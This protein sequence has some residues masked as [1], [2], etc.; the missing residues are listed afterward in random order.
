MHRIAKIVD[1][2]GELHSAL[3]SNDVVTTMGSLFR[4]CN[5]VRHAKNSDIQQK[6]KKICVSP[7]V[8]VEMGG[9]TL[10]K[11]IHVGSSNMDHLENLIKT[12]YARG[13]KIETDVT[14]SDIEW[15][16]F[17]THMNSTLRCTYPCLVR[18][19]FEAL[20]CIQ[21]QCMSSDKIDS[22]MRCL[23]EIYTGVRGSNGGRAQDGNVSGGALKRYIDLT[24]E[25]FS[26]DGTRYVAFKEVYNE[27]LSKSQLSVIL[28]NYNKRMKSTVTSGKQHN[29]PGIPMT[30]AN[31]NDTTKIEIKMLNFLIFDCMKIMDDMCQNLCL[32]K[33]DVVVSYGISEA[34]RVQ[35]IIQS[36]KSSKYDDLKEQMRNVYNHTRK[37]KLSNYSDMNKSDIIDFLQK[38]WLCYWENV[39]NLNLESRDMKDKFSVWTHYIETFLNQLLD[40]NTEAIFGTFYLYINGNAVQICFRNLRV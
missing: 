27:E 31:G 2:A 19:F 9:D 37:E 34:T 6:L 30:I 28:S 16:K 7:K 35:K 26:P 33:S 24:T 20:E 8:T 23:A 17:E 32:T 13:K 10:Q 36:S 15:G 11:N 4:I 1:E 12:A 21:T 5:G 38:K 22:I 39:I 29:Y 18:I 40:K 14:N 25:C 3:F